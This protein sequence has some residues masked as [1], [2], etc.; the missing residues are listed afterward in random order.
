M[1]EQQ[2]IDNTTTVENNE[3][4]NKEKTTSEKK[5]NILES[6]KER[7]IELTASETKK[8]KITLNKENETAKISI[9][10]EQRNLEREIPKDIL[11]AILTNS[12][13]IKDTEILSEKSL[14]LIKKE[15]VSSF[16]LILSRLIPKSENVPK[17]VFESS[18]QA[19][20]SIDIIKRIYLLKK[21]FTTEKSYT[22]AYIDEFLKTVEKLTKIENPHKNNHKVSTSKRFILSKEIL[23][24]SETI[25]IV[26]KIENLAGDNATILK[27]LSY[28]L[29]IRNKNE[30]SDTYNFIHVDTT[31]IYT[32]L[33]LISNKLPAKTFIAYQIPFTPHKEEPKKIFSEEFITKSI[34]STIIKHYITNTYKPINITFDPK[35]LR[36]K[37]GNTGI[38]FE[39][40]AEYLETFYS[41]YLYETTGIFITKTTANSK[42]L[43]Y[44]YI[45]V[46]NGKFL[47]QNMYMTGEEL[48]SKD[49]KISTK[50]L[51]FIPH[52]QVIEI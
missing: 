38:Y 16:P 29:S 8:I 34:Y 26:R 27:L 3:I 42:L 12:I 9:E 48:L 50:F 51:L 6:K 23:G 22:E 46:I 24:Y 7:H 30:N 20:K 5:I 35:E 15:G 13:K 4:K 14:Q 36:M 45:P 43:N 11:S 25:K 28:S 52:M 37:V 33:S 18:R 49:T 2:I 32:L 47:D 39:D 44:H 1:A 19:L 31:D 17:E 10:T 40:K 21:E 41:L